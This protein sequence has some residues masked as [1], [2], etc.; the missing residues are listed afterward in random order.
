MAKLVAIGD[1]LT[2]GF[3]SLAITNTHQSY[4]A[5]I[6]HAMG[7]DVT[8][9][10]RPDFRGKGGLPCNIEWLAR[11]LEERYGANLSTFEWLRAVHTIAELIDEVEDYWERGKG[12]K[13]GPDAAYHNLAVWGFEVADAVNIT[14]ALCR[15]AIEGSKDEWFRPPSSPRLRTALRVLNPAHTDARWD[16]TQVSIA[17]RIAAQEG[18][19]EHLIVWLGANNCLK[20]VMR[21]KVK[22]TGDE[23]PGANSDY[24]LWTPK[25]FTKDYTRLANEIDEIGA[26]NVYVATVPH[27]TIPPIT[28]GIMEDRG[29]LPD[30]EQYFDYYTHFFIRDKEFNPKRDPYLTK[31]DAAKIDQCINAYNET[32]KE[33]ARNRRW[34]VVDTCAMLEQQAVRRNGGRATYPLPPALSDLSVRFFE[35]TPGGKLKNGGLI[36]LDGVHPTACGYALIASEFIKVMNQHGAGAREIDFAEVRRW[37]SLVATPPRTLDDMLSAL[38]TLEKHFH[39]SRWMFAG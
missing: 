27:V 9:F 3:H 1:S 4:P 36:G 17:K 25:A 8:T 19:I 35:I 15:Q 14:A 20:T 37:D 16:D 30:G 26:E 5:V 38:A 6:G 11:R 39:L 32:I 24:T 2:Q 18:G 7:L 34:H 23:P 13:P 31:A 29:R 33:Q 12:A 28:R 22:E 10:Q 21:L